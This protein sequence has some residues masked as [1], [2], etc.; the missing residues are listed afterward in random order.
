MPEAKIILRTIIHF[1]FCISGLVL[2]QEISTRIHQLP[3]AFNWIWLLTC[4]LFIPNLLKIS[5]VQLKWYSHHWVLLLTI[6]STIP[7]LTI[8]S[9]E[10]WRLSSIVI[11][12]LNQLLGPAICEELYFRARFN[13]LTNNLKSPILLALFNGILF[14][15]AHVIS[16]GFDLLTCLTFFPGVLLWIIYLK[17]KNLCTV[18][19]L[20]WLFNASFYAVFYRF[21]IILPFF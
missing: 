12:L 11:F 18:I 8:P 15:V 17:N 21:E 2:I 7:F 13:Q 14:S 9:E 5:K 3:Q 19:L 16:R 10:T 6:F 1:I 4:A 20:H